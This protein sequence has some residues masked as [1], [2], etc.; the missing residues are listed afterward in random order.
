MN[1]KT[2]VF[3]AIFVMVGVFALGTYFQKTSEVEAGAKLASENND[4]FER[5]HAVTLG[6]PDAKVTLVE[7]FDPACEACKAFYPFVKEMLAQQ[8]GQIKTCTAL[9]AIPSGC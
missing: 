9:R 3:T 8:P 5:D 2:L 7:F 6:S 1:K 4:A